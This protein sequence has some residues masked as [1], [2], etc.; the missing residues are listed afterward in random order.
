MPEP[1]S[2]TARSRAA[3]ALSILLVI[4]LGLLS[5]AKFLPLPRFIAAYAGD[6]LWAL[7]VFLGFGWL[8]PKHSTTRIALYAALFSLGIEV[9]QLYHTPWLDA[10]RSNNLAAL[11]LGQGFLWSDLVCYALGI[12]LGIV[13]SVMIGPVP[14]A[15]RN[16][17]ATE[18]G[19]NWK[20]KT[21]EKR[22]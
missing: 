6:T 5:R 22:V 20:G 9:S 10:L 2:N 7:L 8:F 16:N 19:R 14:A 18:R 17:T 12:A 3:Y 4:S 21:G 13:L 11:V 15:Q 1:R